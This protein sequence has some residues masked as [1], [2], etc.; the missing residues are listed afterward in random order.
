MA[1][2]ADQPLIELQGVSLPAEPTATV[3]LAASAK[4]QPAKTPRPKR[5]ASSLGARSTAKSAVKRPS[6]VA[7]GLLAKAAADEELRRELE[8]TCW[9]SDCSVFSRQ[10]GSLRES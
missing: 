7:A 5:A 6:S 2:V 10:I 1:A 8:V 4:P 3:P 9:M